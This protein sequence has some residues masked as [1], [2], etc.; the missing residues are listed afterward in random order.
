MRRFELSDGASNKFWEVDVEGSS[1]TVRFGRIG[2]GGQTQTKSFASAALATAEHDKLVKEKV[3][4]G[5]GEVVA[6]GT[7]AAVA[8]KASPSPSAAPSPAPSPSPSPSAAPSPAPSAS[9]APSTSPAPSASQ[10][11]RPVVDSVAWTDA[12]LRQIA[13]VRGSSLAVPRVPDAKA[14]YAKLAKAA[15]GFDP[16]LRAGL[17]RPDADVG[18][19]EAVR[20]L[21]A[22]GALPAALDVETQAAAYAMLAPP[23][24]WNDESRCDDFVRFWLASCGAVFAFRALARASQL[25]VDAK[26][27]EHV[28]LL[29]EAAKLGEQEWWRA[30]AQ[31]PWRALRLADVLATDAEHPSLVELAASLRP[32]SSPSVRAAMAAALAQHDWCKAD[33]DEALA[34]HAQ[35][36][37]PGWYFPLLLGAESVD[38]AQEWLSRA[39]QQIWH[40]VGGL[41]EIRFDLVARFGPSAAKILVELVKTAG[42]TGAERVR[43]MAEAAA[44]VVT[45]EVAELFVASLGSKELRS[46]AAD[47]LVSHPELSFER[48]AHVATQKGA[49]GDAAKALVRAVVAAHPDFVGRAK[50]EL[51]PAARAVLTSVESAAHVPAADPSE[52]PRV[53]REPPWT[54]KNKLAPPKVVAGLAPLPFQEAIAWRPGEREK[55]AGRDGWLAESKDK[56]VVQKVLAASKSVPAPNERSWNMQ[57]ANILAQLPGPDLLALAPGL[58]LSRFNWSYYG[59]ADIL[60]ARHDVAILDLV[61]RF[62]REVDAVAGAEVMARVASARVAPVM[63]DAFVRLKKAKA[64]AIEWLG[65]FPEAAAVGLIPAAIGAPGKSREAADAA[66]RF[67]AR[68]HRDVVEAVAERYGA[69]AEEAVKDVLDFDPLLTFPSKLPKMPS[70]WNPGAFTPPL[71][72]GREKALPAAAIDAL[73]TMLAFSTLEDPYVGLAD[74]KEACDARSLAEL[75]WDLFQAWLVAGATSKEQWAFLA[76]AHFGGDEEAR[77]LTPLVRAWP[78]EAAHA[79]AVVGLDVLARIGTDVALMHLHG[80]AQKLKFKGLQ[81]KAREKIDQ[82]AEARGLTADELAD[83]LVPDLDLDDDGSLELDFGARKFGVVFDETLKPAVLDDAGKRLP[84]LPKAKQTDDADKSKAATDTWKALKKDSKTIAQSQLLRLEVA[85]CTQRRWTVDVFRQFL[86]GHPLLVHIVR[87]LVWGVYGESGRLEGTFRVAEDRSLADVKDDAYALPDGARVGIVHRLELESAQAAAW[88]QVL[89]DYEI[90]Q[91]FA[92]LSREIATPTDAERASTKLERVVGLTV[93]TGKV[94]GLD[95]RGWRRGPPQDGGVVCWYEKPLGGELVAWLDLEPGIY[96]GM[97]SE[98]PEQKLGGVTIAKGGDG[99][100]PD[101]QA[102]FGTISAIAFSE[103]LR[104]LES[105]RG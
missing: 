2:T 39:S 5:Y 96:T 61:I 72:A 55:L 94:L 90:L 34:H 85:M 66:L 47:Y 51:G 45:P 75:A 97:V 99:W 43:A 98:S 16:L 76:L 25:V 4:K 73:G 83:R 26:A 89:G 95:H 52:L 49:T 103:L 29:G 27:D 15:R 37:L 20:A 11:P 6:T 3:K 86:L 84:D 102:S 10:G 53:L 69:E 77:K 9:L 12:A 44:L 88:A 65:R 63:A 21:F 22:K 71:L 93:P 23:F 8:P 64:H 68:E 35:H 48:L 19:M 42:A 70:F 28:A 56:Q 33:A 38:E 46:I 78:G 79:R 91:P 18:K 60:L 58:T 101:H 40:V 17:R 74:V 50:G 57:N 41:S 87:R 81:E 105:L 54:T 100:R 24:S 31:P 1:L 13:L 30:R 7:L 36:G 80:I 82:I 92:Q 59:V 62:A 67:V 104:D 14:T 32:T